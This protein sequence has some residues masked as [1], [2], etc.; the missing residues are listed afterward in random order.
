MLGLSRPPF[1]D[2]EPGAPPRARPPWRDAATRAA[3]RGQRSSL[4]RLGLALAFG[5]AAAGCA[6]VGAPARPAPVPEIRP[7]ILAGYLPREALPNS[8][9]LLPAPPA[10]GSGA[11]TLDEEVVRQS[12]ALRGTP[13]WTLAV[14]DADLRFPHAAGTFSCALAAPVTDERTPHLYQLLRRTMTDAG[15]AT[16]SAKN[17]Y[18]RARP[19][20][21]N[22]APLCTPGEKEHLE[23]DGSYPSGHTAIGWAWALVLVELAPDR[24]DALL[25]RGRSFGESRNVC[26]VHWRSDVVEGR[27]VGAATVA[28][29]HADPAF[30]ADLASARAEL[31]AVRALGLPASR[32]CA[33]ESAAL[34]R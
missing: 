22:G 18:G 33:A 19:F 24:A 29:L 26:N 5:V 14:S 8:L 25:A 17:A 32:D 9:A 15:L 6:G 21:A 1:A 34:A 16:Y 12:L 20:A 28:R 13:R 3:R 11:F 2:P 27:V 31:G 30:R 7:G 10:A 4:R 23:K